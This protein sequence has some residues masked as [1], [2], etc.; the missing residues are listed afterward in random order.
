MVQVS[1][2]LRFPWW[3]R[4]YLHAVVVADFIGV[5]EADYDVAVAFVMRHVKIGIRG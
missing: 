3:W 2:S 1:L 4:L 5:I